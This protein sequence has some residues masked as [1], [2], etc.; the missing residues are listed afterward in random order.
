MP[1]A[2]TGTIHQK[3]KRRIL[4]D[5]KGFYG[6]R[7]KLLRTAKDARR[8]S[9]QHSYIS[10]R[11]KKRDFRSLW[12]VRIGAAA[13]MCGMSYSTLISALKKSGIALNRKM[14]AD[15]AVRDIEIFKKIVEKVKNQA[16]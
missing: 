4:K 5:A 3:R 12:I 1:R 6:A 7:S 16:A 2:T 14:L 8:K 15:I 9:L 10:R 13:K 11:L